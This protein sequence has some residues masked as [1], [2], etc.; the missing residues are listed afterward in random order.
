MLTLGQSVLHVKACSN[1]VCPR[2]YSCYGFNYCL[3]Y[4]N[5]IQ[6]EYFICGDLDQQL[7]ISYKESCFPVLLL[8]V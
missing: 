6:L 1:E 8:G 7:T 3:S 5:K 4:H 2:H